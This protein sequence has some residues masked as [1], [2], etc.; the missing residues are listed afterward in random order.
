[1][2]D[3]FNKLNRYE[4][5]ARGVVEVREPEATRERVNLCV[6][7]SEERAE[8]GGDTG[9]QRVR[10]SAEVDV[11]LQDVASAAA[12]ALIVDVAEPLDDGVY[13]DVLFT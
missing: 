10:G 13:V 1:M 9:R 7:H 5:G 8:G 12:R 6:A 4:S 3:E 2:V 11:K